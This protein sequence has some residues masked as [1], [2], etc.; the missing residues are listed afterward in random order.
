[1]LLDLETQSSDSI[2]LVNNIAHCTIN[3]DKLSFTFF[4]IHYISIIFFIFF[5]IIIF[6]ILIILVINP[7]PLV[8]VIHSTRGEHKLI[9]I[10]NIIQVERPW[11]QHLQR[12][13]VSTRKQHIL[14]N[15]GHQE[16]GLLLGIKP[17]PLQGSDEVLRLRLIKFGAKILDDN[18]VDG[19]ASHG[20]GDGK[21]LL[22][23]VDLDAP[24]ARLGTEDDATTG[25]EGS[26]VGATAG[27]AGLLLRV[28][29]LAA[30]SDLG[31]SEGGG[32]AAALVLEVGDDGAVN[33]GAGGVGRSGLEVESGL[34]DFVA[35]KG[36]KG[37]SGDFAG[38]G[39]G[40]GGRGVGGG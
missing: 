40:F 26:T 39:D 20:S 2:K 38:N 30:A 29:F 19:G 27:A 8:Q 15:L 4:T 17:P 24:V 11:R 31:A 32:S 22:L 12:A 7:I 28:G 21:L 33:D 3:H 14:R 6:I 13:N 18:G 10:E 34:A 1:M 37:K 25:T 16:H 36:E 35:G 23:A 9:S 5:I